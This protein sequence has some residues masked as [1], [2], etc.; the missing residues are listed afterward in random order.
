[1]PW[2]RLP[3]NIESP[4]PQLTPKPP[5]FPIDRLQ[6]S[7][8][9]VFREDVQPFHVHAILPHWVVWALLI[10]EKAF[11]HVTR[12]TLRWH[13]AALTRF[14]PIRSLPQ[15]DELRKV[16]WVDSNCRPEVGRQSLV[17][18]ANLTGAGG[19]E[20]QS[21][22]FP[23]DKRVQP[24]LKPVDHADNRSSLVVNVNPVARHEHPLHLEER[25][26]GGRGRI[27]VTAFVRRLDH[28]KPLSFSVSGDMEVHGGKLVGGSLIFC[29]RPFR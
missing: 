14:D 25:G 24:L 18:G 26:G 2:E 9:L 22:T 21:V 4:F 16:V 29:R 27:G 8:P 23:V 19:A 28:S 20:S 12:F 6:H 5:L 17:P 11:L 13:M 15:S 7:P 1:M 10:R 3:G